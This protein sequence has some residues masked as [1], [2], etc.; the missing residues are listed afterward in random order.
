MRFAVSRAQSR[1]QSQA[2]RQ[3]R[4]VLQQDQWLEEWLGFTGSGK[5]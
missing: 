3:R 1:A 4:A 5:T 2:Y